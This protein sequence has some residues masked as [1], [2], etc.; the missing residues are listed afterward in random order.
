MK[1]DRPYDKEQKG[2]V[3]KRCN[4]RDGNR[5]KGRQKIRWKNDIRKVAGR[6]WQRKA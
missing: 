1:L 6:T 3:D 4:P 2:K 5:R